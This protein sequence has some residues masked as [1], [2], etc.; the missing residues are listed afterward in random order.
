M[1]R[2]RRGIYGGHSEVISRVKHDLSRE[3]EKKTLQKQQMK[4]LKNLKRL[5]KIN[6]VSL[7]RK[8]YRE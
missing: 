2:N 4:V 1:N 7:M 6:S 8:K 3:A 5:I